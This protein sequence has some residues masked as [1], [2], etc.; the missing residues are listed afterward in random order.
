MFACAPFFPLVKVVLLSPQTDYRAVR[1]G[2][3]SCHNLVNNPPVEQ[4]T[5]A[6]HHKTYPLLPLSTGQTEIFWKA[7]K[8]FSVLLVYL[9]LVTW[10]IVQNIDIFFVNPNLFWQNFPMTDILAASELF[11]FLN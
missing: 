9:L 5:H 7:H 6:R 1:S 2:C 4:D 8:T 3:Q 10:K 11:Y